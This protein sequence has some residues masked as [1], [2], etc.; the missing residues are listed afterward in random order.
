MIPWISYLVA[1]IL[2]LSGIVSILFCGIGME[3][4]TIPNLSDKGK[5]VNKFFC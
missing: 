3:R 5:K 1:D 2:S 4:Y